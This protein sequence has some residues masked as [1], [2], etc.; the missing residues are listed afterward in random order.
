MTT[1]ASRR[2]SG[3]PL[4]SPLLDSYLFNPGQNLCTLTNNFG[5]EYYS[6]ISVVDSRYNDEH[7]KH[8]EVANDLGW[9][10]WQSSRHLN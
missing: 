5:A 7:K 10:H 4:T 3:K 1:Q 2:V 9:P 8:K 6:H